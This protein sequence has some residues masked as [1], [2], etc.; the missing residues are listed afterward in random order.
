MRRPPE[1]KT[2][3]WRSSRWGGR[4]CWVKSSRASFMGF[5][6]ISWAVRRER[7]SPHTALQQCGQEPSDRRDGRFSATLGAEGGTHRLVANS[8]DYAKAKQIEC[9]A[10][11]CVEGKFCELRLSRMLGNPHTRCRLGPGPSTL[12]G[13]R[14]AA[15]HEY[16]QGMD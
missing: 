2:P 5:A 15:V 8:I 13:R 7:S 3:L 6:P 1:S 12:E 11:E 9:H 16:L 10:P 14:K 4:G